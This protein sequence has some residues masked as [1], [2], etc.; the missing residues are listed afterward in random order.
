MRVEGYGPAS[1]TARTGA[2]VGAG[3]TPGPADPSGP[4]EPADPG[5]PAGTTGPTGPTGPTG[6]AGPAL[7]R[8]SAVKGPRPAATV[9]SEISPWTAH[10]TTRVF[11]ARATRSACSQAAVPPSIQRSAAASAAKSAAPPARWRITTA[12]P[13]ARTAPNTTHRTA[14]APT[15]QTVADPRSDPKTLAGALAK[16]L[17]RDRNPAHL[18]RPPPPSPRPGPRPRA[19]G[20]GSARRAP[21]PSPRPVRAPGRPLSGR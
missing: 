18:I 17:V 10:R 7:A 20:R 19:S 15:V 14:I 4:A 12:C 8:T 2:P 11:W 3:G 9:T 6:L 5:G 21:A 1:S 16:A 13:I